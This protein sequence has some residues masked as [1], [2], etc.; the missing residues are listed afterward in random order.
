MSLCQSKKVESEWFRID[1]WV[2]QGCVTSPW[3]FNVYMDEVMKEVKM[4][5]G[6]RG[7]RFLYRMVESGDCLVSCFQMIWFYV[8]SWRVMVGWFAEV[9]WRRGLKVNGGIS[10]VMLL[11]G[12]E[13]LEC[14]VHVDWIRFLVSSPY[15]SYPSY[16]WSV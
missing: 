16:T 3:L 14:E 5:M 7:V 11:N 6:R 4:G 15:W 1:S 9:C 10:K 13:G 2:K 12:E 8:V